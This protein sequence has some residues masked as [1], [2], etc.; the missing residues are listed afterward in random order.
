MALTARAL[1]ETQDAFDRVA[2]EYGSA[3]ARNPVLSSMRRRTMACVRSYIAPGAEVLDLGCGP[4]VDDEEL[5]RHG[6]DVTAL[7][8]SP[9]MVAEARARIGRAGLSHKVHVH[10][11]GIHELDRLAPATFDG[12]CSNFGALN[13]VPDLTDLA[14]QLAARLRRG[15]PL[16]ASVIGRVCPWEVALF[17]GKCDTARARVRFADDFVPVPLE[18]GRVWTKYYSPSAF[19]QAFAATGFTQEYVRALGLLVPPPYLEGFAVRHPRLVGGLQALEDV[20]AAWPGLRHWGD[21]F[22]IVLRRT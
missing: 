11:L 22:L 18:G 19:A 7:D 6:Y 14:R 20:V 15:A 2:S 13:C 16:V 3:N 10:H 1:V 21:H 5:G 17:L 4:G 12:A 8:W 9:A